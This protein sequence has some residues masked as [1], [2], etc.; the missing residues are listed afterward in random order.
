[1]SN[2]KANPKANPKKDGRPK[3]PKVVGIDEDLLDALGVSSVEEAKALIVDDPE[4]ALPLPSS[5]STSSSP[6]SPTTLSLYETN[7]VLK[8][9]NLPLIRKH[10]QGVK[11]RIFRYLFSKNYS[12]LDIHK[13]C[14]VALWPGLRYQQV[15]NAYK[16]HQKSQAKQKALSMDPYDTTPNNTNQGNSDE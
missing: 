4:A 9:E 15:Y 14:E 1:M 11:A 7:P 13:A 8:S 16:N 12:I 3:Q 10:F 2:P 5:S 6:S